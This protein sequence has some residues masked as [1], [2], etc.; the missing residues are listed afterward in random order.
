MTGANSG[1]GYETKCELHETPIV[2]KEPI[3]VVSFVRR[4]VDGWRGRSEGKEIVTR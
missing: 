3:G 2:R 1:L 4:A